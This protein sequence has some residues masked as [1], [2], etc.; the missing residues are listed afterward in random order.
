[1][2]LNTMLLTRTDKSKSP[3]QEMEAESSLDSEYCEDNLFCILSYPL[4]LQAFE[5][6][7]FVRLGVLSEFL[8]KILSLRTL[9]G[10]ET[11]NC[12]VGYT[13]YFSRKLNLF[14]TENPT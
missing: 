2:A 7:Q 14:K 9:N 6:K 12:K 4:N 11:A 5:A 10:S 8:S 3:S 13:F 1:M